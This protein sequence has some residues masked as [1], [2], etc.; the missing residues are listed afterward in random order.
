[1]T[2]SPTSPCS[3]GSTPRATSQSG[4]SRPTDDQPR[5]DQAVP[6]RRRARALRRHAAA[7]APRRH[8][9][10]RA[11]RT[12]S[13]RPTEPR[14]GSTRS[15]CAPTVRATR[16]PIPRSRH[17]SPR[18]SSGSGRAPSRTTGSIGWCCSA[19]LEARD[20]VIVRALCQYLRQAG[21]RFTDAYLA[22]TLAREPRRG[23]AG[24][25][26]CS[27]Q[28]LDPARPRDDAAEATLDADL[29]RVVDAVASL[30][31][32]RILRAL[33]AGGAAR[34]CAPTPTAARRT[35]RASSTRP[36]STSSPGRARSTRSGWRRRAVEGVHLRAGDIARGGI[37]WSDRREDFR[38][39][40][41]GLM[42]AQTV[43]N[44]VIVPVGAK[45][46][47]VVKRGDVRGAYETFIRGAARAH[48][49]PRR[50][51]GRAPRAGVVRRDGDD[52]Y[53]V[54]AA[55]KGTGAFSDLANALAAEHDYWLG[56]AFASGGSAGLRPQGDGHHVA[57][58]VDLGAGAL[59]RP[60]HRR[61]HRAAHRRRHRRHVGRRVRQRP[62]PVAARCSWSPPSTTATC[63]STP[64]PIPRR[65]FAERQRLFD[66]A[67]VVV[68]RLRP[69]GALTGRRCAT[70]G[71]R[72]RST[73]RRKRG[74]CSASTTRR[75]RP[76]SW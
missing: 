23:A 66:A 45:G 76:T 29:E 13:P 44:A 52:P 41:L 48:R 38:T 62:A 64:I 47:F 26:P 24:S 25:S 31:A 32:D 75:S 69:R 16:S 51:R 56:D 71:A 15:A 42:K 27:T 7:R 70:P 34:P 20:V 17:G 19:G 5:A 4:W 3:R 22:D 58:R 73:C 59:P 33:V 1:M 74:A 37:R 53:L 57:G 14:A 36:R 67:D 2:R 11:T 46:G 50:R 6:H 72:S 43:K 49:Q 10:R 18:C 9:G 39:E 63:S 8:R 35:S 60:R 65:R 28:R 54:V 12:R 68:G 21:V 55:D 61:R 40:V 30:D